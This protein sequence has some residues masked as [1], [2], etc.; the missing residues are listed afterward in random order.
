MYNVQRET[1]TFLTFSQSHLNESIIVYSS[2][3][4][5]L[6]EHESGRLHQSNLPALSVRAEQ[7][8]RAG[9]PLPQ[10]W[11]D[12]SPRWSGEHQHQKKVS[13][14]IPSSWRY[15]TAHGL[16]VSAADPRSSFAR[17]R[18]RAALAAAE[19]HTSHAVALTHPGSWYRCNCHSE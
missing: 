1:S 15:G 18:S 7:G 3:S 12:V 11:L 9:V 19:C 4:A 5:T 17:A 13:G 14:S 2:V 16:T 8:G 6:E 10:V